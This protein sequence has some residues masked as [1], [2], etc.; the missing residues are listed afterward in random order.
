MSV[1]MLETIYVVR[2]G[3]SIPLSSVLAAIATGLSAQ[4]LASRERKN[5]G[6]ILAQTKRRR[7]KEVIPEHESIH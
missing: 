3:V 6:C 2:H 4:D 7:R 5:Y 1:K